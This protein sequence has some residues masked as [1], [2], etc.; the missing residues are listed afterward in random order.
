M[1]LFTTLL[2]WS[3]ASVA[4]AAGTAAATP[5]QTNQAIAAGV[6]GGVAGL[7]A[8]MKWP[9]LRTKEGPWA[10]A[11]LGAVLGFFFPWLVGLGIL[12]GVMFFIQKTCK[13]GEVFA[14]IAQEFS[15]H[16][17]HRTLQ[18]EREQEALRL[19]AQAADSLRL[20]AEQNQKRR[21]KKKRPPLNITNDIDDRR[22][23]EIER[24]TR[25]AE[26]HGYSE[27]T[28]KEQINWIME[29]FK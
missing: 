10:I 21:R 26:E 12:G 5:E 28:L 14:A 15:Q 13:P 4:F 22:E 24:A 11:G 2:V 20:I 27:E 9:E 18:Q 19:K 1:R 3:W 8:S 6:L 16:R 29:N 7:F 17:E 23:Q 25:E